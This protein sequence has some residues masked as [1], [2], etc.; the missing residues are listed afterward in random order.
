MFDIHRTI[1]SLAW[2]SNAEEVLGDARL[3]LVPPA[4]GPTAAHLGQPND[5]SCM[6]LGAVG[7]KTRRAE[8][9]VNYSRF[10]RIS[11]SRGVGVPLPPEHTRF[12]R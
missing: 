9:T 10:S 2:M 8:D 12:Q 5:R 6:A 4:G 7:R 11:S 1:Q 3:E